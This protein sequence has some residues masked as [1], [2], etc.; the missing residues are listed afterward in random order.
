M[1]IGCFVL[2]VW[3]NPNRFHLSPLSWDVFHLVF[4]LVFGCS[5]PF[6]SKCFHTFFH[7]PGIIFLL[8]FLTNF[9]IAKN[10]YKNSIKPAPTDLMSAI[11][12]YHWCKN[13][14][15][16]SKLWDMSVELTMANLQVS[17]CA[18]CKLCKWK[19]KR[20]FVLSVLRRSFW[21]KVGA[22]YSEILNEW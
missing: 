19:W 11:F 18:P 1:L 6:N 10:L 16:I 7:S 12:F 8:F 22:P 20:L 9:D 3:P 15:I 21:L 13:Y 5:V 2:P 4:G 17:C 14:V